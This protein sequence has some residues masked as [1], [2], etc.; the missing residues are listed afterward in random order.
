MAGTI[1]Q[2]DT[3]C[4]EW[5]GALN[6]KGYGVRRAVG[7]SG[8]KQNVYVHRWI[9]AQIHGWPALLGKQV[10]HHCDNP[11]CFRFDHLFIGSAEANMRDM[12][13]KGRHWQQLKTHCPRGHELTGENLVQSRLPIRRCRTCKNAQERARKLTPAQLARRAGV[14][15][16][17]YAADPEKFRAYARDAYHRDKA[18]RGE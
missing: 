7:P 2:L 6:N 13:S 16:A 3:P 1:T 10:N 4:R 18:A 8:S 15:K 11:R 9:M 14:R 5:Q 17:A 12:T